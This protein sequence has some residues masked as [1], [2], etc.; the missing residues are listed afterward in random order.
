MDSVDSVF[1]QFHSSVF[2]LE[3]KTF[4]DQSKKW[5]LIYLREKAK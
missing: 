2:N 5:L 4:L 1:T 3:F